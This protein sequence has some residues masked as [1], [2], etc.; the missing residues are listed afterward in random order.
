SQEYGDPFE[1]GGNELPRHGEKI[2]KP[3]LPFSPLCQW[4]KVSSPNHFKDVCQ[5]Y[6][7]QIR[8]IYAK[9]IHGFFESAKLG[10]T[11]GVVSMSEKGAGI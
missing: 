1:L 3:L 10:V 5:A 11:R 9:E 6:I 7:S 8:P 4:L 2:I